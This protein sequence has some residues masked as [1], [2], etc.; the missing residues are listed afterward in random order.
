MKRTILLLLLLFCATTASAALVTG[1]ERPLSQPLLQPARA[2]SNP[3]VAFNGSLGYAVWIDGGSPGY[4]RAT[5][6]TDTGTVLDTRPLTLNDSPSGS[7][8]LVIAAGNRFFFAWTERVSTDSGFVK[9]I[10]FRLIDFIGRQTAPKF[11]YGSAAAMPTTAAFDGE[12]VLMFTVTPTGT[13]HEQQVDVFIIDGLGNVL[14]QKTV[15]TFVMNGPQIRAVAVRG[16][17]FLLAMNGD[18]GLTSFDLQMIPIDAAGDRGT[19]TTVATAQGMVDTLA[20]STDG[21]SIAAA[22]SSFT[23]PPGQIAEYSAQAA[24]IGADGSAQ[25][26]NLSSGWRIDDLAFDGSGYVVLLD[27]YASPQTLAA[28]RPGSDPPV[29]VLEG[30]TTGGLASSDRGM[31]AVGAV[32][33][34]NDSTV[35]GVM[36]DASLHPG[37]A[38]PVALSPAEQTTPSIA[39]R[40]ATSAMAVWAEISSTFPRRT[41]LYDELFDARGVAAG[42]P[43]AVADLDLGDFAAFPSVASDGNGWLAA[44]GSAESAVRQLAPDGQPLGEPVRLVLPGQVYG[45]P[46]VIWDGNRYVVAVVV[47]AAQHGPIAPAVFSTFAVPVGAGGVLG[48]PILLS[49]S[50]EP[51]PQSVDAAASSGTTLVVWQSQAGI[52]GRFVRSSGVSDVMT[53]APAGTMPRVVWTGDHFLVA[54]IDHN[55]L[56][57]AVVTTEGQVIPSRGSPLPAGIDS[58][59]SFSMTPFAGGVLAVGGVHAI[60]GA[61]LDADGNLI[62]EVFPIVEGNADAHD[63]T[64]AGGDVPLVVYKRSIDEFRSRVFMRALFESRGRTV[65]H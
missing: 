57:R 19:A 28:Q 10:A 51:A 35:D 29:T 47:N 45:S 58:S 30:A 53:I 2:G 44:W 13:G 37:A 20:G 41:I 14:N 27:H 18:P 4:V 36:L 3:K 39:R 50:G 40:D 52:Q 21:D 15:S 6:L 55:A 59:G 24:V 43:T 25:V 23:V 31:F 5:R 46:K 65:R 62:E 38:F 63:A 61:Q 9:R 12:H 64:V 26:Y 11:A 7:Q 16:H 48:Q 33:H 17:V 8:P 56:W 42:A 54:W 60:D 1:A 22:W 49:P 34:I 32:Q